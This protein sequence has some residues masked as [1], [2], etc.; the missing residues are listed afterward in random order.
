MSAKIVYKNPWF[1]VLQD[2]KWHYIYEPDAH[3]GAVIVATQ[4]KRYVMVRVPRAAHAVLSDSLELPRGYGDAHESA[5]EAAARE[6]REETGSAVST[7]HF[8]Q[9]GEVRPNTAI[10]AS[11][12]PVFRCDI[13]SDCVV[14]ARD[15][16]ASEVVMLTATELRRYI[17]T[18]EIT[19][20]ITLAAL[21]VAGA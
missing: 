7:E 6:L 21:L 16:E 3:N 20:A 5:L 12:L 2:G 1:Q 9:L 19:C 4:N 10:L 15:N 14:G 8:K 13:P 11:A 17:A 18:G